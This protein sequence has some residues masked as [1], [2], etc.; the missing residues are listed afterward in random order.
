MFESK[1]R[2]VSKSL[3]VC[4]VKTMDDLIKEGILGSDRDL[5]IYQEFFNVVIDRDLKTYQEFFNAV[6][7]EV[8]GVQKSCNRFNHRLIK[9]CSC[10]ILEAFRKQRWFRFFNNNKKVIYESSLILFS[11]VISD[12]MGV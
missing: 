4:Y 12:M 2:K 7:G 9:M 6:L 5:K 11:M 8:C 3:I 1:V 10:R